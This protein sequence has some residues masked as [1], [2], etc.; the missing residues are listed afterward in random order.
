M[1]ENISGIGG[2]KAQLESV[3]KKLHEIE[4]RHAKAEE[5]LSLLSKGVEEIKTV[6]AGITET[7]GKDLENIKELQKEFEKAV[8]T[9]QQNNSQLYESV[10]T[11]LH[12]E[13]K[14][15]LAPIKLVAN[16]FN[17]VK[18]ELKKMQD[19]AG[20]AHESMSRL[21]AVAQNIKKEDFELKHF[22][23]ELM[24]ADA[25]KLRLMKEIETLKR[26]ISSERRRQR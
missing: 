7:F 24:K 14:E 26:I 10:Y 11:K 6:H 19:S 21:I 23:S 2:L 16:E 12:N 15:H 5:L 4:A 8:R 17:A 3:E 22:A 9:F 1:L 20:I 13:L 25:E 18:P